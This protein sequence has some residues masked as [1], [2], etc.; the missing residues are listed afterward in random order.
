MARRT[1]GSML[2]WSIN[3]RLS[4]SDKL[5]NSSEGFAHG[6]ELERSRIVRGVSEA[7]RDE[8]RR[9]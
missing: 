3:N 1:S 8:T 7:G 2:G 6:E 9:M 4:M 5:G